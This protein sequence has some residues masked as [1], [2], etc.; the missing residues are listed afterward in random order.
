MPSR[1][2]WLGVSLGIC[3]EMLRWNYQS[4]SKRIPDLL[5]I[6][7]SC[8]VGLSWTAYPTYNKVQ[9]RWTPNRVCQTG[10]SQSLN[11][12]S[13]SVYLGEGGAVYM[14]LG[15]VAVDIAHWTLIGTQTIINNALL[16]QKDLVA[17]TPNH[18]STWNSPLAGLGSIVLY[19]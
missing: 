6:Y 7:S 12:W 5:F 1:V 11:I 9:T 18:E 4:T 14:Q 17:F 2:K 10:H 15:F 3:V 19:M 13:L 8:R 16:D